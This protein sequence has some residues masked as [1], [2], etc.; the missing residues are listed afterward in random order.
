MSNLKYDGFEL[1]FF[2]GSDNFR[3]YQID[4]IRKY[5]KDD[6]LEVGPGKGGLVKFYDRYLKKITLIEPEKK[7]YKYLLKKFSKKKHVI[8][9]STINK[10]KKKFN[11][12]LYYDVLEHIKKDTIEIKK[13][14]KNLKKN[15]HLIISVPAFQFFYSKFDKA[16]GHHKR[17]CKNDFLILA[18]KTNLKIVKLAYYDSIGFLL[19]FLNKFL[20]LKDSD[21]IE[22]K[23]K[24]WNMLIPISRIIDFITFNSFG[25]SLVCVFKKMK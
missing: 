13:A 20:N 6:L 8:K 2:D 12:I 3:K 19:L 5:I 10:I 18:K 16:V 22:N 7:L 15:G 9:N 24:I 14:K 25:K 21:D 23:I 1:D 11:T 17:Y 4:L